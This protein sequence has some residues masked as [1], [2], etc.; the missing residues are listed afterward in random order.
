LD[1][2]DQGAK[3]LPVTTVTRNGSSLKLELK[4]IGGT[5]EGTIDPATATIEGTWTQLGAS[6]PLVL[7]RTTNT[8]DLEPRRPQNPVKP[9][10]YR[11]EDVAY[12]NK[13]AQIRLSAT[14][15]VPT[16]QGP[17]PAV[18][19][20]TGSGPQDRDESL[21]GHRPFLVLADYLTRHG[22]VVRST[23]RRSALWAIA[24]AASL[25]R[26]WPRATGAW[27]SSC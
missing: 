1:S 23:Q 7:T 16:G 27:P 10:P 15:T 2:L 19:L 3:G 6:R 17:F 8:A 22:I 25:R 21:M 26:W 24:K 14:L 18:V 11:E 9:Y 5:F 13:A 12:D 20:L 4:Q